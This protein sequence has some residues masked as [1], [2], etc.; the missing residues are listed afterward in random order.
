MP[1]MPRQSKPS[2]TL[3]LLLEGRKERGKCNR[4]C[5]L[6]I[7][8]VSV[9]P[10]FYNRSSFPSTNRPEYFV[11]Y[12]APQRSNCIPLTF[13]QKNIMEI[14][15]ILVG[16]RRMPK[17]QSGMVEPLDPRDRTTSSPKLLRVKIVSVSSDATYQRRCQRVRVGWLS[18]LTPKDRTKS[19][20]KLFGKM[21]KKKNSGRFCRCE[22]CCHQIW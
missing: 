1:D 16:S 15:I 4:L 6:F 12:S 19:S 9:Y 2:Q 20:P 11:G 13:I 10:V 14:Y 21:I 5:F 8:T 7:F 18:H 17:G 22:L 3:S